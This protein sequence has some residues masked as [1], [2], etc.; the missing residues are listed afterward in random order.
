MN[1]LGN[2]IAKIVDAVNENDDKAK[3]TQMAHVFG[4]VFELLGNIAAQQERE[5]DDQN[6]KRSFSFEPTHKTVDYDILALPTLV[7]QRQAFLLKTICFLRSPENTP[8]DNEQHKAQVN[9]QT[10]PIS[11]TWAFVLESLA[12]PDIL[13]FFRN[14]L[15]YVLHYS[16]NAVAASIDAD[17]VDDEEDQ[18]I[19]RIVDAWLHLLQSKFGSR[20]R[21]PLDNVQTESTTKQS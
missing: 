8:H 18:P 4:A 20:A 17:L 13:G 12:Q 11:A 15:F 5:E 14:Q 9:L 10:N 19:M 3:N 6:D 16:L 21:L 2:I 1:G 7:E